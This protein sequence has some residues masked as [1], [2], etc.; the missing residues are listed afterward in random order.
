MIYMERFTEEL[1]D[2]K[3]Q[4]RKKNIFENVR[5]PSD[6]VRK[7]SGDLQHSSI[8]FGSL[9]VN[10]QFGNFGNTSVDL[11]KPVRF[12]EFLQTNF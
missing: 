6:S 12:S 2:S 3:Y 7:S 1:N 4:G 11:R 8:I 10:F 9:Q 5:I